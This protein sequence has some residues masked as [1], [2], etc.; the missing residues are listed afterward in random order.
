MPDTARNKITDHD[1]RFRKRYLDF[2]T[3]SNSRNIIL[4]RIRTLQYIRKYLEDKGDK[5][6][7]LFMV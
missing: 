2:L 6:D 7:S 5:Q 1:L 3:N 4:T